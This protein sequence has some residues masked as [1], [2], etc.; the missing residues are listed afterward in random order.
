MAAAPRLVPSGIG[1][2]LGGL[3]GPAGTTAI[4]CDS[5]RFLVAL[6]AV[7]AYG[8]DGSRLSRDRTTR[9]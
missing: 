5:A 3:S 4:D 2:N 7:M 6:A 9:P 1:A 8:S